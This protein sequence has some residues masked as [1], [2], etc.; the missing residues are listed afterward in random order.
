MPMEEAIEEDFIGDMLE[1][2]EISSSEA[3]FMR[4]YEEDLSL[5]EAEEEE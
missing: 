3:G 5:Q 4:G 1:D 2:D